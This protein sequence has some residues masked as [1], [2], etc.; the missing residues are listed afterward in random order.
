VAR[1]RGQPWAED[2]NP[3]GILKTTSHGKELNATEAVAY[4]AMSCIR[5][6]G[7]HF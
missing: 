4:A 3:V 6:N 2:W 5:S 1:W 7:A